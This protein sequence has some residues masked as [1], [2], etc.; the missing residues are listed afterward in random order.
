MQAGL[1]LTAFLY[2]YTAHAVSEKEPK[3]DSSLAWLDGAGA[4]AAAEKGKGVKKWNTGL[5]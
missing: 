1:Q 4:H 5:K 2:N 3:A